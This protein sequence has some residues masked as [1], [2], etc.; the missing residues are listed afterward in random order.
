MKNNRESNFRAWDVQNKKMVYFSFYDIWK[1][2][3]NRKVCW[4][5]GEKV[6]KMQYIGLKDINKKKIYEGDIVKHVRCCHKTSCE[7]SGQI[8]K[9]HYSKITLY[10]FGNLFAGDTYQESTNYKI[11]GNICENPELLII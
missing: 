7:S 11:I 4:F 2:G 10:P 9:V 1:L 8:T 3:K 6:N 5:I